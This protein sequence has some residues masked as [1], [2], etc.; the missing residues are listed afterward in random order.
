MDDADILLSNIVE[1]L[2]IIA[3]YWRVKEWKLD[4]ESEKYVFTYTYK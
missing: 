4:W 1:L 3:Y 2:Q